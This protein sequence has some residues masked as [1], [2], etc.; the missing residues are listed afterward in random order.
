MLA[1]IFWTVATSDV[2]LLID[3]L[4]LLAALIVGF[5]PL[6]RFIP[7]VGP[8]VP[9]ARFVAF[10]VAAVLFFMAGFRISDER[11]DARSLREQLAAKSRDL[12]AAQSAAAAAANATRELNEQAKADQ[13]RIAAY[14]EALK[15]RPQGGC[16]LDYSDFDGGVRNG[17][18]A[19]TRQPPAGN[20]RRP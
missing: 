6:V 5:A 16:I 8:Y 15:S 19:G 9:L 3:G 11:A 17:A 14:A 12:D 10:A 2:A 4:L 1:D 20:Q 18:A 13:E 7:V